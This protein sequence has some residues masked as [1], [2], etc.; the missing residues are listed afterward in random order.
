M[1]YYA[2]ALELGPPPNNK[3]RLYLNLGTSYRR[4]GQSLQAQRAYR[5]ALDLTYHELDRNPRDGYARSCLAYLSARLGDRQGA[6][7]N[8][9]QALALAAGDVT[10]SEMVAQTY[11]ALGERERTLALIGAAPAPLLKMLERIPDLAD[12]QKDSRFLQI[13]AENHIH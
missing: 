2:R 10:V 7:A 1:P 11:E 3:F 4:T 8:A 6:E 12:L 5:E 13:L 9:V